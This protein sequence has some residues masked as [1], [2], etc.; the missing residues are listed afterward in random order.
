MLVKFVTRCCSLRC[1]ACL[2]GACACASLWP[3][4]GPGLL[5]S[6]EWWTTPTG[7]ETLTWLILKNKSKKLWHDG[8]HPQDYTHRMIN[9]YIKNKT[10]QLCELLRRTC[11][12]RNARIWSYRLSHRSC[13]YLFFITAS[14][15]GSLLKFRL[16]FNLGRQ[17]GEMA[18]QEDVAEWQSSQRSELNNHCQVLYEISNQYEIWT[19]SQRILWIEVFSIKT[20]KQDGV[21]RKLWLNNELPIK[22]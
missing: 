22:Y 1:G 5:T 14:Y 13:W 19:N 2:L 15:F 11:H 17:L 4:E 16:E 6:T 10:N 9:A 12:R 3:L 18:V 7:L 8:L 21:E 20:F